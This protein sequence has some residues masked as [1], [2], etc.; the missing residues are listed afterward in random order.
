MRYAWNRAR[1]VDPQVFGRTVEDV[2]ARNGGVCPSWALVD[3]ARPEGSPLHRM[4][5]W[6]DLVAAEAHRRN[7]ARQHIRELRIVKESEGG[8]ELV[9]AFVHVIRV[10][11]GEPV[12]GYR[13][14]SLVVKSVD[15]YGQVLDEA[16]GQLRAWKRRY[17]HLSE[18]SV[19]LGVIEEMV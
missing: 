17:E 2:S 14:T 18:L 12:E 1:S 10:A 15:E 16:L 4:F 3:E 5:E 19:V 8:E 13:L 11:D 6:D 9:Q 7:Q